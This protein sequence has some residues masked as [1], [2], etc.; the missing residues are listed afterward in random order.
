MSLSDWAPRT[1]GST[2]LGAWQASAGAAAEV[3][4]AEVG[5]SR[6]PRDGADVSAAANTVAG[7]SGGSRILNRREASA[8]GTAQGWKRR[9]CREGIFKS[10]HLK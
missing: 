4:V 5:S 6:L 10:L 8:E 2:G 3:T 7:A 9:R 1:P